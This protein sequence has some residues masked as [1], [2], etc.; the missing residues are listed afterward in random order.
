LKANPTTEKSP[1]RL[2]IRGLPMPEKLPAAPAAPRLHTLHALH[3][4]HCVLERIVT[5]TTTAVGR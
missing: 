2:R 4:G 3:L 1:Y 5:D